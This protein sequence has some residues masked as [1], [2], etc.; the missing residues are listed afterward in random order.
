MIH[1]IYKATDFY[2]LSDKHPSDDPI[3]KK[4]KKQISEKTALF[5]Q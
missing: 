2:A 3:M 4:I 5:D 1:D